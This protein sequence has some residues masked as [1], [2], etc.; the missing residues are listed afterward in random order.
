MNLLLVKQWA[1][2][3]GA[4]SGIG[5]AFAKRFAKDGWNVVLV[6][7]SVDKLNQL[8]GTLREKHSIQTLVIGADLAKPNA[9]RE[10]HEKVNHANIQINALVNNAGFGA[11]GTF[12]EVDLYRQLEMVDVNVRALLEL[13]HLFLPKMVEKGEGWVINVSSTASFQAMPY[14]ATYA[15]T[16]AFVTFFSE[17][18]WMEC[19][20]TGVKV[21]NFCPGRTKTNFGVVAGKKSNVHDFRLSQTAEE[22]VDHAIRAMSRNKPTVITNPLDRTLLWLER[23][24]SRKFLVWIVEKLSKQMGYQ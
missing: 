15:A 20:K 12:T 19:R 8:A 10:V 11:V 7:R 4:S 5:K 13:T 17:A 24:C 6:A 21:I 2:I 1:L 18:L 23:F 9:C 3:T 16:K 22:V 14:F